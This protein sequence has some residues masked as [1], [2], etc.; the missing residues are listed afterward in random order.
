MKKTIITLILTAL[1]AIAQ[2]IPLKL[3]NLEAHRAKAVEEINIKFV[4]E[5]EKLKVYYTKKSDL[6][7]AVLVQS[8]ITKYTKTIEEDKK[9]PAIIVG[10]WYWKNQAGSGTFEIFE[11]GTFTVSRLNGKK[12]TG[13]WE[14]GDK[15]EEFLFDLDSIF[16]NR[17][18]IARDKNTLYSPEANNSLIRI[19]F[20][21]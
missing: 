19:P 12:Q 7:S 1:F 20:K 5:L 8:R 16:R 13:E 10:K 9:E 14:K 11:D 17:K 3:K 6:G 21:N 18:F 4:K 15:S 2:E